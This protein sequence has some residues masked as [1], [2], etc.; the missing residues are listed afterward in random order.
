MLSIAVRPRATGD[1][2]R[3]MTGLH[4]L[5]EEDAA[6]QV[7]QDEETH[8]T[9]LSGMGETHLLV[10]CERLQRRFGVEID[11]EEVLVPYR[12]TITGV[13]ESEGKHKKQSGGHGQ[14]AVAHLRIEPLA[15]G[16]GF[17]FVDA[18]VG[19][20][21]PRQFIPAVEKGVRRQ[22]RRG[23]VFGFPVIDVKVT[24]D[25]GKFHAVDSNEMS[26]EFAAG[27]AVSA[28]LANAGP[29]LLEPISRIDVSVPI[30]Y[31]GGV[32]ADLNTRRGRVI[33][34]Q[35]TDSETQLISALVPSSE[36]SHYVVELRSLT[37]GQ[38]TF[39][40]TFERYVE[41]PAHAA[42]KVS[43]GALAG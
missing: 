28:A 17:E 16:E 29:V 14:F 37:G 35:P 38:G 30:H 41:V 31:Q 3:L 6:L 18:V 20:A 9:V 43:R 25:G 34:N 32:L 15:R 27:L 33:D 26:F 5:A 7:H 36:L 24:C 8:Q 2:D 40:S 12:E 22:L 19:G 23:G 4:R 1:E 13:A 11:R 10:T 21:I 39:T 42:E